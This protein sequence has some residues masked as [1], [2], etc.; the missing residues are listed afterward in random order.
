MILNNNHNNI[1]DQYY[2]M[3]GEV[4]IDF[5]VWGKYL[6]LDCYNT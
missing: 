3:R 1:T 4:D 2:R 6:D 5:F